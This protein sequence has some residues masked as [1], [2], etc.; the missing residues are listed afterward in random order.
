MTVYLMLDDEGYWVHD[1][2]TRADSIIADED[3]NQIVEGQF[4]L[5][6]E[7]ACG[8]FPDSKITIGN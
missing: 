4:K 7:I 8:L 5:A 3:G 6:R 2:E 1:P